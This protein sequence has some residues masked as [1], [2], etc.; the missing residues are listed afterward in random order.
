VQQRGMTP[1]ASLTPLIAPRS[2]A[3]I[4]A[5]DDRSRIGGRPIAY[6]L[7]QKFHGPIYPVNP[8]REVIQGLPAFRSLAD[9]PG[10]VDAAVIAVPAAAVDQA[11]ADCIAKGVRGII[12]FTAGF[13][14]MDSGGAA[15]QD[16]LVAT[17]QAAGVR[18]LGPNCLGLFNARIGFYSMFTSSVE[19]GFPPPGRV[20]IASQSGAFGAH[21][22]ALARDRGVGTPIVVTTGNEAD[23]S[24]GDVIGWLADDSDT[25]VIMAYIEGVKAAPPLLAALD[26]ARKNR[27]PVAVMKVGSSRL[28][29][30]AAQSH[31]ASLTGDDAVTDA[32]FRDYGVHRVRTAEELVDVAYLAQKRIYPAGN[33]LGVLTVSGGAGVLVSD[34]AEGLG[35]PLPPMPEA[36]QAR[37][38]ARLPFASP[39][40]PVDVTAQVINDS[41]LIGE[42]ATAMYDEGH[43]AS[44]LCFFTQLGASSKMGPV[45]R[46]EL[47]P[48]AHAHP[49]RLFVMSIVAEKARIDDWE[50]RGI[51]VISDPTRAT[52]AIAAMGFFG[53][54]FAAPAPSLPP[55]M[56][57]VA[58]PAETPDEAAAKRILAAI[59]IAPVAE[60][61][62][63]SAEEA[64]AFAASVGFPVV[65]KIASPDILHKSEIGGVL[66][67]LA[68]AG[69]VRDAY[70]TLVARAGERA[71]HARLAGILVARQ[72]AG[73]ECIIGIHRDPVFGPVAMVGLGGIFVEIFGDVAHRLCPFGER[74]AEALIRR[75]R[76]FPLLDGARGRARANV[77]ALAAALARLS[78][79]AAANPRVRAIDVNPIIVTPDGAF[80][81]DAVIELDAP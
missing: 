5:S 19:H 40:N 76:G 45:I 13:A 7:D 75:L 71:P 8:N 32:V 33:T 39:L 28:G 42:F 15:H 3:V 73:V 31:T 44:V 62:C 35:L 2:L 10:P 66:L 26:R 68:D 69:A 59:G 14:E 50:S 30:T 41:K 64:A 34:A 56:P 12:L 38:K 74:E 78:A 16:R 60:R 49:D 70:A 61:V 80:A 9:V 25:D 53:D 47:L 48:V 24:V 63:A 17:C 51:P 57:A 72:V 79:F 1:F 65:A 67:N 58:L 21:V 22:F 77:A 11:V 36:T 81:A 23:V 29:A 43:Y 46:D 54:A 37:L 20:A 52:V 18:L 55:V 6:S 27:K 4:G